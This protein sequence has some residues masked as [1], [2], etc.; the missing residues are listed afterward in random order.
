MG[1]PGRFGLGYNKDSTARGACP[2]TFS[3]RSTACRAYKSGTELRWG[4]RIVV[5]YKDRLWLF[6]IPPDRF[7][8]ESEQTQSV[9]RAQPA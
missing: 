5:G 9:S 8:K 1:N 2:N 3:K 6:V 4:T 7:A